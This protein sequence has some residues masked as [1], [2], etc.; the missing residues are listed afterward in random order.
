MIKEGNLIKSKLILAI[1][2]LFV[3]VGLT[4]VNAA[5]DNQTDNLALE[6][7]E[8]VGNFTD[9]NDEISK[10]PTGGNLTLEKDYTYSSSDHDYN[11]GIL[12]SQD[13]IVIDGDG[14]TIDGA[15]QTRIF[16][17]TANNV[18]LKNINFVNGY[19]NE[20]GGAIYSIH[21]L[22]ILDSRFE[23]NSASA[24]GGAIYIE[25]AF[26][27]CKINSTFINNTAN[28]G[29]A[30]YFKDA[31]T[32][33]TI[34]GYFEN[35]TGER[36]AGAIYVNGQSKD[37][38]F[39]AQFYY[40]RAKQVSGGAM[41]FHN[42]VE[43][44]LCESIFRYNQ[45]GYG[46]G[47]FFSTKT[48]N[49]KFN[50]DF[51]FNVAYSCGGAMFF[52]N[53]TNNNNFTGYFI[54]NS[55]LGQLSPENGNGG[56]ITFKDT[57]TNSIFTC[58]FIN[59]TAKITGGGVNYRQ[60]PSNITF[61]SNFINNK[62]EL[63]GGV[64]FFESFVNVVF[65]GKFI[66]NYA[67]YGG[68][69]AVKTGVI[70]N[71]SF[72]NNSAESGGA[73]FFDE[74]GTVINCNFDNNSAV[75]YGDGG[76]IYFDDEGTITSCNFTNNKADYRSGAV[77]FN[78]KGIISNSY[79]EKNTVTKDSGGAVYF[80]DDGTII[81]CNFTD[82]NGGYYGGAAYFWKDGIIENCNFIDNSAQNG[83]S[84]YVHGVGE[85][86]NSNFTD[87]N[88]RTGGA[89]EF[90][91]M[92]TVKNSNFKNN[93][94]VFSGGAIYCNNQIRIDNCNF[95]NNSAE[96]NAGGAVYIYGNGEVNNC[97]FANNTASSYGGAIYFNIK[98]TVE[99]C[100]FA[101]N[102]ASSYGGAI[103]FNIEGTV[104]NC[105]FTDNSA[106]K[107]NGGA[108]WIKSGDVTNCNFTNNKANMNGGSGGAIASKGNALTI[109]NSKFT[110]NAAENGGAINLQNGL[111]KVIDSQ[112]NDN[113]ANVNNFGFGGAIYTENS[114]NNIS[115]SS[116]KQNTAFNGGA[117]KIRNDTDAIIA[118]CEFISNKAYSVG[119]G[120]EWN[121]SAAGGAIYAS[122]NLTLKISNSKFIENNIDS[123]N[124]FGGGG[125]IYSYG[126][127]TVDKCIFDK[128][129]AI[130]E[131]D[132]TLGS[133]IFAGGNNTQIL[134]N[135]TEIKNGE[136]QRAAVYIWRSHTVIDNTNF[137]NNKA[138]ENG[139]ALHYYNGNAESNIL[140]I[141]NSAFAGNTANSGGALY[142]RNSDAKVINTSFTKNNA[143]SGG[144]ICTEDCEL[145]IYG[146]E[147]IENNAT[148]KGG[149]IYNEGKA[150]IDNSKFTANNATEGKAIQTEAD[151]TISNSEF[152][153][154]GENCINVK[155]GAKITLNNVSSDV[156]LV[157]DTIS[158]AILEAK[159]VV[160][161][162]DVNIKIQVNS[163]VIAQL[164]KGKVVVKINGVEYTADVKYGIATLVIP[165]LD[166][167]TYNANI[168]YVD[169]NISRA[170]IP[171]N[172]TVNK[173]DIAI[174]AKNAAYVINYGGTYKASFNVA[175]GNKVTFTLNGKKIGT[176]TI[177]NGVASIKLT[178]KIL[179]T[180]KAG[181]KNLVINFAGDANYNAASKT[182]RITIN[183]EKQR[184]LPKRKPSGKLLK[185]KNML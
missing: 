62:G 86:N 168:A 21:G 78:G 79:F 99:N 10:I 108:L 152:I 72:I 129:T 134:I 151:M 135:N 102:T 55:A 172:F 100:N 162:N 147:F 156:P 38:N 174:N 66:G 111:L 27:N 22:N 107:G 15:G 76:A 84:I 161:G 40:N 16:N 171:V 69:I 34:N 83:G 31:I 175:D 12:I 82:N 91:N 125:A 2:V 150:T 114:I 158:M 71:I 56:A 183:K 139:G 42:L 179:K 185:S 176:S 157:N 19:L 116:F 74:M 144:A 117:I 13:N 127:L 70:E 35:N 173:K 96:E 119:E 57:S 7:T 136:S 181:N 4:A 115:K 112:F 113:R 133:A 178:A 36:F 39:S 73:I 61:N 98:G 47:I 126:N 159:D 45:A 64:N 153:G 155:S 95:V 164:N 94:G 101:N 11:R 49:N 167:G 149:A 170:E 51:R 80:V 9:L 180:A 44:N 59:N 18:T 8:G 37:N 89:I 65:N 67:G 26:S 123:P 85:V 63:G 109:S 81:N 93:T 77:H 90:W 68:A 154:N 165:K 105:N 110:N 132:L 142:V 141:I 48:N 169:D 160:Y 177:K 184:W 25:N 3:L 166:P 17:I 122:G 14:H 50:C 30:I 24:L 118:D 104:E 1:L 5:D 43:N 32:K 52:Y 106:T 92:G 23:N 146:S 148:G 28:S 137:T 20:N 124:A 88:A 128:N 145:E 60:T 138:I 54:N 163:S 140:I 46:A 87:N 41:F 97:N 58:D 182:V 143:Q 131:N 53:T 121:E 29:G 75:E 103:Y 120:S 6:N 130:S 33:S